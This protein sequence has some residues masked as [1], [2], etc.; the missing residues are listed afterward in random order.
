MKKHNKNL[1]GVVILVVV[2]VIVVIIA[3]AGGKKADANVIKI[4]V[5][6][7][8]T[9]PKA[10]LGEGLQQSIML[11]M[12]DIGPTK[13]KYDFIYEDSQGNAVTSAE[14]TQQLISVNHVNALMSI[15]SQDGNIVGKAAEAAHIPSFA[16]A[17]DERVENGDYSFTDWVSA[18]TQAALMVQ[19]LQKRGYKNV[20]FIM[21][22]ND[23]WVAT[24]A[25]FQAD[26]VGTDIK[27]VYLDKFTDDV[28]DFK[29]DILKMKASNPS[30]D[31]VMLESFSP[32]AE[33]FVSQM[34]QLG[35]NIPVTSITAIGTAQTFKPFEG[36]WYVSGKLSTDNFAQAFQAQAGYPQTIGANYG[37]DIVHILVGVFDNTKNTSGPAI[38]D[39]IKNFD[40]SSIPSAVGTLHGLSP[41]GRVQSDAAV[42]MIKDG[43]QVDVPAT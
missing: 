17:N 14:V 28:Q 33:T 26:I 38:R 16:I 20:A 27:I 24:L 23:A 39:A 12:K 34:K 19:E 43:K 5:V 6:S 2:V 8:M 41:K 35:V 15:T 1:W 31:I 32:Y 9:G 30:P 37:Y 11:A 3:S 42:L 36:D 21:E 18:E 40:F 10:A 29:T 7:P 25:A 13:K 4:G 22:Q